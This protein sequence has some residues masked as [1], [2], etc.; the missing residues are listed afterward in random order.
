VKENLDGTTGAQ[1]SHLASIRNIL[2][3]Y[4]LPERI[5]RRRWLIPI[6]FITVLVLYH[7]NAVFTT[8]QQ[9]GAPVNAWDVVISLLSSE[10]S[11]HHGL[12]NL[13]IYLVSDIAMLEEIDQLVLL[14]TGSRWRWFQVQSLCIAASVISYVIVIIA[15]IVGVTVT[16]TPWSFEW[17]SAAASILNRQGLPDNEL[18]VLSPLVTSL[19]MLTLLGLTWIGMGVIVSAVTLATRKSVLGF[20]AGLFLNYSALIIWLND[21]RL[22]LLNKLWFHQRMFLWHNDVATNSLIGLFVESALYWVIWISISLTGLWGVC[23]SI[24]IV[25]KDSV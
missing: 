21:V 13:L 3:S 7:A 19:F 22:P 9:I 17:S 16:T 2:V 24:D 12:T 6:V 1:N 20:A 25:Q 8:A 23:R 14:K 10:L 4:F 15:V 18:L 5:L 11:V